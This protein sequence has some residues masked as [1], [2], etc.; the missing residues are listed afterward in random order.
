VGK[1]LSD[2][3]RTKRCLKQDDLLSLFFNFAKEYATRRVQANQEGMKLN[4]TH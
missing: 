4:G 1:H 3:F 2:T